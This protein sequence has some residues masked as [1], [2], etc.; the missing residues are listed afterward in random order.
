MGRY[1]YGQITDTGN[2]TRTEDI[3]ANIDCAINFAI[4]K[5]V[6]AVIIA[7]DFYHVKHPADIYKKLLAARFTKILEAKINLFLLVGNHDHGKTAA[8]NLSESGELATQIPGLFIIEEPE[9]FESDES[10]MC[11]MPCLNRIDNNISKE[12]A[13]KDQITHI[14]ELTE[15]ATKSKSKHKLFFGHFGTSASK[16]G[17][18]FDM[19][20]LSDVETD[21]VPIGEFSRKVWTKVYLGHIHL[22]QDVNDFVRHVGSIAK[23]DFG[24]EHEE[25]GFYFFNDGKDEFIPVKDRAFKTL[26]VDLT[27]APREKMGEFCDKMQ[28]LDLTQTITRLKVRIKRKDKGLINFDSV[29]EYLKEN[30]WTFIGTSFNEVLEDEEKTIINSDELN[31]GNMF[32]SYISTLEI[33]DKEKVVEVGKKVLGEIMEVE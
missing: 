24:E 30:S 8:H 18:S 10:C 15:T 32:E 16:T 28:D 3:L 5:K 25:K 20:T 31:Y 2:D 12:T 22:Q 21:V 7:G 23:V 1:K 29:E 6:D 26:S 33:C 19:G 4:E 9:T 11:F 14:R 17:N 27:E 13:G